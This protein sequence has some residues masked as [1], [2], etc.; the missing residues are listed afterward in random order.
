VRFVPHNMVQLAR[1]PD[2]E[3]TVSGIYFFERA[4]IKLSVL[5]T[6][7][8]YGRDPEVAV[9][10]KNYQWTPIRGLI[11]LLCIQVL[12]KFGSAYLSEQIRRNRNTEKMMWHNKSLPWCGD[13]AK[14]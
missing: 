10:S 14:I 5:S 1:K 13:F 7:L 2:I 6:C 9:L 12:F 3:E 11:L 4:Q 8:W